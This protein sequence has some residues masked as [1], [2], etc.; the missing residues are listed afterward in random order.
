MFLLIG[1][2][3]FTLLFKKM[4]LKTLF[5]TGVPNPNM[6]PHRVGYGFTGD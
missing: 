6:R 1:L 5:K 3:W 2:L 4:F